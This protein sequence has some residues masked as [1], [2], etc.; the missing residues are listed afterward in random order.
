M[1]IHFSTGLEDENINQKGLKG[2]DSQK[3]S[4]YF[5]ILQLVKDKSNIM[6]IK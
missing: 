3:H 1:F 4:W 5:Q 6:K 2:F